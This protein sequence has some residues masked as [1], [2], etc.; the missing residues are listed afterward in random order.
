MWIKQLTPDQKAKETRFDRIKRFASPILIIS[1]ALTL[2]S[3]FSNVIEFHRLFTIILESWREFLRSA[4]AP[5]FEFINR[6]IGISIDESFAELLSFSGMVFLIAVR[7][8]ATSSK[9]FPEQQDYVSK[10]VV[11]ASFAIWIATGASFFIQLFD[12]QAGAIGQIVPHLIFQMFFTFSLALLLF[13]ILP[14]AFHFF[15]G[16]LTWRARLAA[17]T[18]VLA[19]AALVITI[20]ALPT[21]L[22]GLFNRTDHGVPLLSPL[23]PELAEIVTITEPLLCEL[24]NRP[25]PLRSD[26]LSDEVYEV[27]QQRTNLSINQQNNLDALTFATKLEEAATELVDIWKGVAQDPIA[28]ANALA[29]EEYRERDYFSYEYLAVLAGALPPETF[30]DVGSEFDL[31]R[32]R[33]RFSAYYPIEEISKLIDMY[34]EANSD[35]SEYANSYDRMYRSFKTAET[36]CWWGWVD[37]WE[38]YAVPLEFKGTAEDPCPDFNSEIDKTC[39]TSEIGSSV[40]MAIWN[41]NN[42]P[43]TQ[44]PFYFETDTIFSLTNFSQR[45][46]LPSSFWSA[47]YGSEFFGSYP[48]DYLNPYS[49]GIIDYPGMEQLDS[50]ERFALEDLFSFR[51]GSWIRAT[52]PFDWSQ[53]IEAYTDQLKVLA[54]MLT[55]DGVLEFYNE[56]TVS[57]QTKYQSAKQSL[58]DF[59]IPFEA[60]EERFIALQEGISIQARRF[61][62]SQYYASREEIVLPVCRLVR[63]EI[64]SLKLALN[65]V[66]TSDWRALR[67]A[68]QIANNYS[69]RLPNDKILMLLQYME[70]EISLVQNILQTF[71]EPSLIGLDG[72]YAQKTHL[73]KYLNSLELEKQSLLEKSSKDFV[74]AEIQDVIS[75]ASTYISRLYLYQNGAVIL[76][77]MIALAAAVIL[78]MA[79]GILPLARVLWV[80]FILLITAQLLGPLITIYEKKVAEYE[81]IHDP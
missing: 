30:I 29:R 66:T 67:A 71:D 62:N 53:A 60:T 73:Q 35:P 48:T 3:Q 37:S 78:T 39:Y 28:Y 65:A 19:L 61:D 18:A 15:G 80:G 6:Y 5:A 23:P 44:K 21:Q 76:I 79:S 10:R 8:K 26:L 25:E 13:A 27:F 24:N 42:P 33:Q 77:S 81:A 57:A 16:I 47:R 58:D 40:Y 59:L 56:G 63:I 52:D 32:H 2:V 17:A 38:C 34:S 41:S 1:A 14:T 49:L 31:D 36:A 11:I 74:Q 9:L 20:P 54:P 70:A 64:A 72:L 4:W 51:S 50:Y 45:A 68:E 22:N 46:V 55:D 12:H 75:G 7:S 43:D 69:E